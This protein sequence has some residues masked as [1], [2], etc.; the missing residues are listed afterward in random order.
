[1]SE[2]ALWSIARDR[3]GRYGWLG[4][5]ENAVEAGWADV[6]YVLRPS[7]T[8]AAVSGWLELKHL[9]NWPVRAST[10]VVLDHLTLEQVLFNRVVTMAGG[11]A[12]VLMQVKDTYLLIGPAAVRLLYKREL[13][14]QALLDAS[15][16]VG[17]AKFPARDIIFELTC[18]G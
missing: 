9:P 18:R 12:H 15:S 4:R 16:V 14:K 8:R 13:T 3:L 6:A 2:A 7:P 11:H 10:P 17:K 5:L 1:M